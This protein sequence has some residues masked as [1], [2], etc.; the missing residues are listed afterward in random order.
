MEESTTQ[1]PAGA[2]PDAE[3]RDLERFETKIFVH[4]N[5]WTA[6]TTEGMFHHQFIFCASRVV[7]EDSQRL[8]NL[9]GV[10][11]VDELLDTSMAGRD[12][13]NFR[14]QLRRAISMA[15]CHKL[16]CEPGQIIALR[17]CVNEATP[18]R[19]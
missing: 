13:T 18:V 16:E 7:S 6:T 12:Q 17:T 2:V 10:F 19:S 9:Q 15:I 3:R 4:T 1:R 8:W 5:F 11:D 14:S